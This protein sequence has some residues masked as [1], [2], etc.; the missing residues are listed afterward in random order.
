MN[1]GGKY[2]NLSNER[3]P[4]GYIDGEGNPKTENIGPSVYA[5]C[6]YCFIDGNY[7]KTEFASLSADKKRAYYETLAIEKMKEARRYNLNY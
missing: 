2:F 6:Y 4:Y 3:S 5:S 1:H 7:P